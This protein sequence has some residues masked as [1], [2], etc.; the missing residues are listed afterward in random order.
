[1]AGKKGKG[2]KKPAKPSAAAAANTTNT[3]ASSEGGEQLTDENSSS[4]IGVDAGR[5]IGNHGTANGS[6]PSGAEE[7]TDSWRRRGLL[8]ERD[9]DMGDRDRDK[10]KGGS[11]GSGGGDQ[12]HN[13]QSLS[14]S[15][16]V[17]E[18]AGKEW[19]WLGYSAKQFRSFAQEFPPTLDAGVDEVG[20][21]CL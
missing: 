6:R 11:G 15:G 20:R 1:M 12:C 21:V 9:R 8:G 5:I 7:E 17:R 2:R 16:F 13:G 18:S 4:N 19:S 3:R 10:E 14:R